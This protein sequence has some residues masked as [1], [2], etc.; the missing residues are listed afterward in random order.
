MAHK[1]GGGGGDKEPSCI[2]TKHGIGAQIG[3]GGEGG[4]EPQSILMKRA[5]GAQNLCVCVCGEGAGDDILL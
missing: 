2:L 1:S 3:G 4:E 5:N